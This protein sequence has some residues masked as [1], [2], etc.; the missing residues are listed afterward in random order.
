MS[1]TLAITSSAAQVSHWIGMTLAF[2]EVLYSSD[3]G[4]CFDL[5]QQAINQK[6]S[7]TQIY[8]RAKLIAVFHLLPSLSFIR[9]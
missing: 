7:K 8:F 3:T 2:A 9:Y 6:S 5:N 4:Q 1:I